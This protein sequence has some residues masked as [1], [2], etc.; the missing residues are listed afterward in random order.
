MI[1]GIAR[2]TQRNIFVY[3]VCRLGGF[4]TLKNLLTADRS[5]V[6]VLPDSN[7]LLRNLHIVVFAELSVLLHS[8]HMGTATKAFNMKGHLSVIN[9]DGQ[10]IASNEFLTSVTFLKEST[11]KARFMVRL[12]RHGWVLKKGSFHVESLRAGG[13]LEVSEMIHKAA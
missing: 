11:F 6:S 9:V 1:L 10:G 2:L 12:A 8:R 7:I 5:G 4:G 3:I 13:T